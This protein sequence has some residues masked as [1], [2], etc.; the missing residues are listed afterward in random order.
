MNATARCT[1]D[2]AEAQPWK[3]H[4]GYLILA[5]G[6]LGVLC[7]FVLGVV[8]WVLGNRDL[9]E[10]SRGAMNPEGRGLTNAGRILGIISVVLTVL[11]V[12]AGVMHAKFG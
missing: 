12:I 11:G 10:M 5:L 6:L 9:E 7:C 3:S 2:Q 1:E 4:R 8:A